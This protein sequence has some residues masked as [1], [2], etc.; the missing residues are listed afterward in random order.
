ML[1]RSFFAVCAVAAAVATLAW[2]A[3][4]FAQSEPLRIGF[5][6]VRSGPLAAG[7]RQMEE[8]I[9]LF[10]KERNNTLAGRKVEL[11]IA[12]TGGNPQGAKTKTQELVERNN[13]AVII[14]PLATFEALAI[15]DYILQ[16]RVPLIT[17]TSAAQN[18][19]AQQKKNDYVIHAVGTAAQPT[20]VLGQY[21]AKKLGMK[22]VAMIADD[23]AYGHEGAA[24]FLKVFEDNGGHVVQ[25]LWSP[26]TVADYGSFIAQV[27]PNVDGVYAG[28]AGTNGLK[29]LKQYKEYQLKPTVLGNPT[30]V[31]EGVLRNMGDEAL[32]VYSA[33]WYSAG[34]DS[35]DNQRFVKAIQAEYKVTPGFYTAGTYTAG[36]FLEEAL[37]AVKGRFEDKPAFLR[38][39]HTAQLTS[40]PMGPIK[41]DE[42][43]KPVMNM[44]I[45]KVER[46]D[47]QLVNAIVETI[48]SVTQF[49]TYDP[50]AFLA[51]PAYS[52]DMPA[53]RYLE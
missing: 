27:K 32:G 35:A 53:A 25:R 23:F 21:A 48:P 31:D 9:Q 7:G 42:Y 52:R 18:D 45:R 40:G 29:F 34:I 5:L 51:M 47:G 22:R 19:L 14:G 11:V 24:G 28:F 50:K 37:K 39:L 13:V 38:A 36:L 8:G 41:L 26:L 43:G 4:S 20:H 30:S 46:K 33:S 16:A 10:L 49:W 12:D 1:R 2:P 44:Y 6:T 3:A 15:D 17:P